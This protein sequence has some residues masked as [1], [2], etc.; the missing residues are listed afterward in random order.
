MARWWHAGACP[1]GLAYAVDHDVDGTHR[2]D[3]LRRARSPLGVLGH[4]LSR[5]QDRLDELPVDVQAVDG[6]VRRGR[7]AALAAQLDELDDAGRRERPAHVETSNAEHR[8]ALLA[9]A[10][11]SLRPGCR[12]PSVGRR[13]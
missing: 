5:W 9:A 13:V 8:A 4:R 2:G 11:R 10:R 6:D 12:Y 3:A 1:A 7:V